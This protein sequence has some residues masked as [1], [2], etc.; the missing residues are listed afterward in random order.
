MWPHICHLARLSNIME[1]ASYVAVKR[2][3]G[4]DGCSIDHHAVIEVCM[5][6]GNLF[7]SGQYVIPPEQ[8]TN[9][10]MYVYDH[11]LHSLP[12]R[13]E[14]VLISSASVSVS[15]CL[16]VCRCSNVW[17]VPFQF[18]KLSANLHLSNICDSLLNSTVTGASVFF[19][20]I[21]YFIYFLLFYYFYYYYFISS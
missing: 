13:S 15:V 12:P 20:F 19:I 14:A 6:Q 4:G 18:T 7:S 10:Y 16:F 9:S 11:D 8:K 17:M 5:L 1:S 3:G 21:F 2:G